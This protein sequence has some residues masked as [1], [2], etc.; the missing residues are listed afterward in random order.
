MKVIAVLNT[1]TREHLAGADILV[2][3]LSEINA[4]C[5]MELLNPNS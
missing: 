4:Q 5:V 1:Q 3:S 2:E